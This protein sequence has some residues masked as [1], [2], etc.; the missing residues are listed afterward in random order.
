[1]TAW[2]FDRPGRITRVTAGLIAIAVIMILSTSAW[3][4][5]YDKGQESVVGRSPAT[6]SY[7]PQ[8]SVSSP[9]YTWSRAGSSTP[10]AV[11]AVQAWIDSDA[12][13]LQ[14]VMEPAAFENAIEN[15]ADP[16]LRIDGTAVRRDD[17]LANQVISVPTNQ[18][19]LLV[20]LRQD[21]D[22][23]LVVSMGPA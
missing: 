17:R 10:T 11:T 2:L 14:R 18:G 22:R 6:P 20:E 16:R 19:D 12:S 1:M 15:P 9:S 23:W 4:G 5:G 3:R 8:V 7:V 21:S 13:T